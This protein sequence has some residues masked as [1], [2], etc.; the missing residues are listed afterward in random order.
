MEN[1]AGTVWRV[2]LL[3]CVLVWIVF[4]AS[5]IMWDCGSSVVERL[6]DSVIVGPG[7]ADYSFDLVEGYFFVRAG[8]NRRSVDRESGYAALPGDRGAP[9]IPVIDWDVTHLGWNERFIVCFQSFNEDADKLSGWW[10]IDTLDHS[11]FGPLNKDAYLERLRTLNIPPAIRVHPVE[12]YGRTGV[13][14][15]P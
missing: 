14:D 12:V 1:R 5:A 9:R 15:G 4:I 3:A 6:V 2:I 7:Q 11:R 8:P 10:I 13:R